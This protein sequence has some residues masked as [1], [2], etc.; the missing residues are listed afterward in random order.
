MRANDGTLQASLRWGKHQPTE[1][2]PALALR[3]TSQ[4][5][6]VGGSKVLRVA[7]APRRDHE[8]TR[9][10]RAA[11]TSFAATKASEKRFPVRFVA[12]MR[13]LL[14]AQTPSLSLRALAYNRNRVVGAGP[15]AVKFRR[16]D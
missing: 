16:V 7:A 8:S 1:R 14:V 4:A 15:V 10:D 5:I 6:P 3:Q 9:R 2:L 11:A 13:P 12:P